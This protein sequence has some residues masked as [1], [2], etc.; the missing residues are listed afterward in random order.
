MVLTTKGI[1][2]EYILQYIQYILDLYILS[3]SKIIQFL[4]ISIINNISSTYH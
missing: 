2:F 4:E 3:R 1:Y